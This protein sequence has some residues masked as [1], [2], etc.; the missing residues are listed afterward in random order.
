MKIY[1]LLPPI[2]SALDLTF[3]FINIIGDFKVNIFKDKSSISYIYSVNTLSKLVQPFWRFNNPT[4]NYR[5]ECYDTSK[6][7]TNINTCSKTIH[8]I[9]SNHWLFPINHAFGLKL[10]RITKNIPNDPRI[11]LKQISGNNKLQPLHLDVLESH[12]I[13]K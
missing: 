2:S 8:N 5:N 1:Y 7:W 13:V 11:R 10:Q 4:G 3:F 12:Y 6:I 9:S